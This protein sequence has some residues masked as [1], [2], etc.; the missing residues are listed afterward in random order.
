M[1]DR[2]F[3]D[4][5]IFIYAKIISNDTSKQKIAQDLISSASN[6]N[7]FIST[8]VIKE[9]S[10]VF[11][12]KQIDFNILREY[13]EL[14]YSIFTVGIVEKREL[15]KAID[16]QE[17]YKLQ[18]YDSLIIGSAL[19]QNCNILYSEEMQHGQVIEE[20]IKIMNPF[21]DI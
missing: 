5:N 7:G 15:L 20:Q 13:I 14:F 2:I 18:Y 6:S 12:K 10:N 4:S 9:V 3:I 21:A 8:Q 11:C 17:R 1:S 19:E 16:I